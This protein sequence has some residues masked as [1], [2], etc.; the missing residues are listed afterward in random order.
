ML[1]YADEASPASVPE[2]E[3]LDAAGRFLRHCHAENYL[4]AA[5]DIESSDFGGA[6]LA[7]LKRDRSGLIVA[8]L[9]YK[10]N[11]ADFFL[12]SI[13]FKN[14]LEECLHLTKTILGRDIGLDVYLFSHDVPSTDSPLWKAISEI[15][16]LYFIKYSILNIEAQQMPV[17]RF[18][19]LEA[20]HHE[21]KKGIEVEQSCRGSAVM[22]TRNEKFQAVSELS[23][24]EI[25]EFYRLKTLYL[26]RP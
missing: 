6:S 20:F 25:D 13:A 1:K 19:S 2:K 11:F 23:S 26:T 9:H 3:I 15:S 10:E 22:E 4:A 5:A 8:R 16:G 18:E 17:I 24:D 21:K 7:F 12:Q 14:W